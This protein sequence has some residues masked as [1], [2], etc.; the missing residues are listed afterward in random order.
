M[1]ELT[2]HQ[3]LLRVRLSARYHQQRRRVYLRRARW[4][5]YFNIAASLGMVAAVLKDAPLWLQLGLPFAI[6]LFTLADTLFGWT[7]QAFDHQALYRR[8]MEVERWL[9]GS[10]LSDEGDLREAM[11]RIVAIEADE[12]PENRFAVDLCDN[13]LLRAEGHEPHHA[14]GFLGRLAA[15]V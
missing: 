2:S 6:T 3:I 10:E 9:V 7:A 12:P 11:Q 15:A 4:A 14:V 13:E 1:A 8:W 5:A